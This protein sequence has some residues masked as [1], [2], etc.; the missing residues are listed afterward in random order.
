MGSIT[1]TNRIAAGTGALF[2]GLLFSALPA[3]VGVPGEPAGL[4]WLSVHYAKKSLTEDAEPARAIAEN[5]VTVGRHLADVIGFSQRFV[6]NT[7]LASELV[8]NGQPLAYRSTW[9]R[10]ALAK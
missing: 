6:T 9:K 7:P 8:P 2:A 1:Y 4:A 5:G 10:P 3:R